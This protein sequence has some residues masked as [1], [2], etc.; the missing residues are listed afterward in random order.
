M[1]SRVAGVILTSN[2]A[3]TKMSP[4]LKNCVRISS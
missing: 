1:K 4:L 3:L 2:F